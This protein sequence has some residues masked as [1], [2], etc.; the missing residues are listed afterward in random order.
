L[1]VDGLGDELWRTRYRDVEVF[2]SQSQ[3]CMYHLRSIG[4]S[5][6]RSHEKSMLLDVV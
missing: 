2:I 6:C 1:M 3:F 5:S 4:L